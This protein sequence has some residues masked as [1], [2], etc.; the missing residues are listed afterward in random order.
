MRKVRLPETSYARRKRVFT[1][2]A[3]VVQ[4]K[5][6]SVALGRLRRTTQLAGSEPP[7]V[8]SYISFVRRTGGLLDSPIQLGVAECRVRVIL[9][10]E[11]YY[12]NE[13]L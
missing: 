8:M 7:K 4:S 12:L 6:V 3:R 1:R 9:V 5:V 10:F 11:Y 2:V 13:Y